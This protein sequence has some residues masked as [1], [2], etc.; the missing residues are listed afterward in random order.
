MV[1]EKTSV[2]RHR[3]MVEDPLPD[4]DLPHRVGIDQQP[5]AGQQKQRIDADA[6]P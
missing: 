3:A 2:S 5:V 1:K 6:D 4:R